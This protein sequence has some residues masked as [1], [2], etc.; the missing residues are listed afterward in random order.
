MPPRPRLP[1]EAV[2]LGAA[3]FLMAAAGNI[4][5]PL[6]PLVQRDLRLDYSAAGL[7][8]SA[9]GLARLALDLPAGLLERWLGLRRL[10]AAG[11]LLGLLG[12]LG[13]ALGPTFELVVLGRIASGLGGSIIALVVLTT[14][15][16]RAP[17]GA[18]ARFMSVS[19]LANNLAIGLFPAV[20]GIMGAL[21]GWRATMLLSAG[22]AGASAVLLARVLPR[23]RESDS[24]SKAAPTK[25]A[26]PF[27]LT[28]RSLVAIGLLLAGV[29]IY[30]INRHGF[31]NT[32]IPLFGHDRVGLDPVAIASAI[33]LMAFVGLAVA[34]PGAALADRWSRRGVIVLG[35]LALAVGDLAFLG[36]G[37]YLTFMLA[38][39]VLGLGDF[40]A[41]S[42]TAALTESV[43]PHWR[44]RALG[45]YRFAV[46]MGAAI[47]PWFLATLLD[48]VGF[49]PMVLA[50]AGL[51]LLAAAGGAIGARAAAGHT[52]RRA[53]AAMSASTSPS[54]GVASRPEEQVPG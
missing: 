43:P 9:Y 50:M 38:A 10:A 8:V 14:L 12:G 21:W 24:W 37:S 33:T 46:D 54:A 17:E 28:R 34:I 42:Q 26:A 22:L 13:A 36:A 52:P 11:T 2:L 29:V 49:Q 40:F 23:V 1:T 5:T 18:R 25:E 53:P 20:G 30:M 48:T 3:L 51:L 32:A 35:F 41:A 4:L 45:G 16:E 44:S 6:L 39:L 15:S 19:P 27:V 7:L 31:R 47:G